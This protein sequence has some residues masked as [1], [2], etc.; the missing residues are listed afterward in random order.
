VA[1]DGRNPTL[2]ANQNMPQ[3]SGPANKYDMSLRI[4]S[5]SVRLEPLADDFN[6]A[7][8]VLHIK[9]EPMAQE[10]YRAGRIAK[11]HYISLMH[12]KS[13]TSADVATWLIK[14]SALVHAH[15]ELPGWLSHGQAEAVF[16]IAMFGREE[17]AA[18]V[19]DPR[20][21]SS[22]GDLNA[23]ILIENYTIPSDEMPVKTWY[24]NGS[25]SGATA[26]A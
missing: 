6:V 1:G 11:R 25:I 9:G 23:S 12:Q 13:H 8:D 7:I 10:G 20:I 2:E 26:S 21:I 15:R 5:D 14:M 22:I 18:P 19:I 3:N 16:W 17:I 24:R 4:W